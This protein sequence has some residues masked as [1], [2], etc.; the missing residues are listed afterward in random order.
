MYLK[1]WQELSGRLKGVKDNA[2]GTVTLVFAIK[3]EIVIP[4]EVNT[5]KQLVNRKIGL[6]RTDSAD[7]PYRIRVIESSQTA[8][9]R[10]RSIRGE[11]SSQ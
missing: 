10:S 2:D 11:V 8:T 5:F 3:L 9:N 1:T 7:Q 6:L 4:G